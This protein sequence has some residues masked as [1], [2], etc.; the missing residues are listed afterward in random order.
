MSPSPAVST[1][2][3]AQALAQLALE[4]DACVS[5]AQRA[6]LNAQIDAAVE[7]ALN[8]ADDTSLREALRQAVEAT[9]SPWTAQALRWDI[10]WAASSQ[11]VHTR[12]AQG[13]PTLGCVSLF[14]IPVVLS[15]SQ[16]LELL[17][18]ALSAHAQAHL[19]QSLDDLYVEQLVPEN[20]SVVFLPYGY[21]R[22]Q[23]RAFSSYCVARRWARDIHDASFLEQPCQHSWAP[24]AESARCCLMHEPDRSVHTAVRYLVG[25]VLSEGPWL[26]DPRGV[27]PQGQGGDY[28]QR[29]QRWCT[30]QQPRLASCMNEQVQGRSLRAEVLPPTSLW[31]ALRRETSLLQTREVLAQLQEGLTRKGLFAAECRAVLTPYLQD[32]RLAAWRLTVWSTQGRLVL[33]ALRSF[34]SWDDAPQEFED[35]IRQALRDAHMPLP[36]SIAEAERLEDYDQDLLPALPGYVTRGDGPVCRSS[37]PVLLPN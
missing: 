31:A 19:Q 3:F 2:A 12:T 23:L 35:T 32:E 17:Q 14:A 20:S 33:D 29:L 25:I 16:S 8:Q 1:P 30:A 34:S 24:P 6:H 28:L 27:E 4:R 9:D 10:E 7:T 26:F 18:P 15:S 36:P 13:Q 11:T 22:E 21:S 37:S 5:Q